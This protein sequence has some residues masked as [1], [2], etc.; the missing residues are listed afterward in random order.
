VAFQEVAVPSTHRQSTCAAPVSNRNFNIYPTIFASLP[1]MREINHRLIIY[2]RPDEQIS[3]ATWRIK[4]TPIIPRLDS[5][6]LVKM[7]N[8]RRSL[9]FIRKP[10]MTKQIA[11]SG[12]CALHGKR[13]KNPRNR[14]RV[15]EIFRGVRRVDGI[16]QTFICLKLL[17]IEA[18]LQLPESRSKS[19]RIVFI[20]LPIQGGSKGTGWPSLIQ[21]LKCVSLEESCYYCS[22]NRR[23]VTQ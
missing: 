3:W 18:A 4:K 2:A 22:G 14:L 17:S 6:S 19:N 11:T 16:V 15:L 23:P 5:K 8:M 9:Q 21:Y 13:E 12:T 7:H 20:Q 1:R 10:E